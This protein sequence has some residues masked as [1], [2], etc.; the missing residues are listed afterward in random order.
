MG[1][2]LFHW[3]LPPC[4]RPRGGFRRCA[5]RSNRTVIIASACVLYLLVVVSH[6]GHSRQLRLGRTERE[7]YRHTRGLYRVDTTVSEDFEL[8]ASFALPTRTNVV[9]ITL[10]TKRLKP[11]HIRGTIRPKLRRKLRRNQDEADARFT[12]SKL[13]PLERDA[14]Q[15]KRRFASS[16]PRGETRDVLPNVMHASL[17]DSQAASPVSSIRIYSQKAPPW[18]SAQDV[19]AMRFL[20][21]AKVSRVKE[22]S[23]GDSPSLLVFEGERS[24][25]QTEGVCGGQCGVIS[26][27]VDTTQV[28]AFHL[29][30]VLGLN[31]TLPAVSRRF[32]FLHDGQPCPV[33][34]WDASLL[35]E[36]RAASRSTVRLT[37]A[38]YQRSLKQRCWH[39]NIRPKSDSGC[40]PV[41]HLEWS[42]LALFD[43][44]L[45]IHNR[46]DPSCCGFRPRREDV[47]V[48]LDHDAKCGDQNHIE[49]TTLIHRGHDPGHLVFTDN[50]GFFDRNED[51]LDFRL[52]EGIKELP[53]QA[54]LVLKN[55]RL[56]E[57]L[58]QSLFLDQTYW[59]SQ[60][61]RRGVDKLIDVVERRATVL[62]TYID[63][64]GIKSITMND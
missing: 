52:L 35:P 47:C 30:R 17:A 54:V 60:G 12:H 64:H 41:H 4:V 20:A 24:V 9:Y 59:E 44:L 22:V 48:Q 51:N 14:G 58:L 33:G 61:G 63:A 8:G 11:A 38:E 32:D 26:N 18:L 10:K 1:K 3:L 56:R 27:P 21:D 2:S 42:Q 53:E 25:S 7:K 13:G 55:R 6:L 57:K 49:L 28:F 45:Q 37:W 39:K 16:H 46:L 15:T 36:G 19:E 34:P 31:R 29:D 50:K 23:R 5:P 40:S 62:L 43:F